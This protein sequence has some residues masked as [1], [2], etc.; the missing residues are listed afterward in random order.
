[1]DCGAE[2]RSA[3][4]GERS[5][6]RQTP[7]PVSCDGK[8]FAPLLFS[9]IRVSPQKRREV[10]LPP[11][12]GAVWSSKLALAV[13]RSPALN[14]NLAAYCRQKERVAVTWC[15]FCTK[16]AIIRPGIASVTRTSLG[17]I[18]TAVPSRS[19][20]WS[21]FV[22]SGREQQTTD[23]APMS[24]PPPLPCPSTLFLY[25]VIL[26]APTP[27]MCVILR[28]AQHRLLHFIVPLRNS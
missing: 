18:R 24:Q 22:F 13:L 27:S 26:L 12:S 2:S 10:V 16:P 21:A 20:A 23:T 9:H 17:S 15:S 28:L 5:L 7:L 1:M 8:P 6:V 11:F 4:D 19:H 14:G 3:P 25:P